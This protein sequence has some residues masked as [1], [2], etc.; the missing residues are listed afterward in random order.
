MTGGR[1]KKRSGGREDPLKTREMVVVPLEE[2]KQSAD[3]SPPTLRA[4]TSSASKIASSAPSGRTSSGRMKARDSGS[5]MRASSP[6]W[7]GP[8]SSDQWKS[9]EPTQDRITERSI[10]VP[11]ASEVRMRGTLTVLT[12]LNAGQVFSLDGPEHTIG[13]GT[14]ADIWI[15]DSGLSRKHARVRKKGDGAYSIEDLRSTN[16]TFIG[17]RRV[18]ACDLAPGDRVQLGPNTILRFSIIDDAEEALQKRLYESSTRDAL[19]RAFNRKYFNERLVA[20]VAHSKRHKVK[21][22]LLMLDVDRFKQTNDTHGHL[23]G[24]MVLRMVAAQIQRLVRVDDLLARFGGEE[25][26]LL[27]RST[28]K[29][30]AASLAERIRKSVEGM[31]VPTQQGPIRVT[32]SIGVA[33]LS[34][35]GTNGGPTELLELADRRLYKAKS[36]GRNRVCAEGE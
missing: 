34:D 22:A 30:E 33:S 2:L 35:I 25:F 29:R 27:A 14:E 20:E 32:V 10:T 12:G 26:A 16:G 15:D 13:R 17:A 1:D 8:P 9:E 36:L 24:D 7:L 4:E 5:G 19:T 21:L 23:V 18:D 6:S 31:E 28:G 11:K 3:D